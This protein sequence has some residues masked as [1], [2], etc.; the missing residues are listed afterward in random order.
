MKRGYCKKNA[1]E[2]QKIVWE[3]VESLYSNKRKNVKEM[4]KHLNS[5]VLQKLN[6]E[7]QST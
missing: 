5:F 2:I 4:D 6:Q 1:N 3:Y 7:I